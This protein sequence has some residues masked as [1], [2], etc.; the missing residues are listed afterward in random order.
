M[1][2][3][4]I[5]KKIE[6][7]FMFDNHV[8]SSFS[9]DSDMAA[10]SACDKALEI[11]LD[12]IAFTDHLDFDYPGEKFLLDFDEYMIQMGR[13]KS[14]YAGRL[15]ILRGI[16]VG[17]QPATV[18]RSRTVVNSHDFD[19][20]IG[21]IHVIDG[22]D[23][24]LGTYYSERS[25]KEA[26][27]GYLEKILYMIDNFGEFDNVGHFYYITRYACYD[28]RSLWYKDHADLFDEIFKK[29]I[30]LGKGFEVNT[31]SFRDKPERKTIEYD[32]MLL[33]RYKELGG[34]M[35]S[36]GSDAHTSNYLGH[37]FDYFS[38]LI[39]SCGFNYTVHFEKRKPVFEKL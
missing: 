13:L 7:K 20:V 14:K 37:K 15:N 31:A 10:E 33:K 28:D 17:I 21:S 36:L 11:G 9:T 8:H 6:G 18:E 34:E 38:E 39:R 23:P 4:T 29:L 27:G 30:A 16:E 3:N 22:I 5:L 26:Y 1:V 2:I 19:Y 24:Y 32:K 12:G 25:P 35:V